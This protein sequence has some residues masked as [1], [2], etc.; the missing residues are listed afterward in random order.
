MKNMEVEQQQGLIYYIQKVGRERKGR[1]G[2]RERREG[3]REKKEG[4]EGGRERK[5]K[6]RK[7][8]RGR[9]NLATLY[10]ESLQRE[11]M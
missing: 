7:G 1:E 5:E 2:E 3:E 6:R 4:R 10:S 9:K 11:K 8:G